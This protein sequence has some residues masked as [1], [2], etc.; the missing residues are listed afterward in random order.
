M[1]VTIKTNNVPRELLAGYELPT[2]ILA[3]EFDYVDTDDT[4][5]PRFFQYRGEWYDA[6]EFESLSQFPN[7]NGYPNWH[8]VQTQSAFSAVLI[9]LAS[10]YESVV[11]GYTHW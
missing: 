3:S 5:S 11:V 10:D 9:R 8:G 4:Y 1:S 7:N 6:Y 2:G